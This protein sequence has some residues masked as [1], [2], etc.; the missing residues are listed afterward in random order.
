MEPSSARWA[1][2]RSVNRCRSRAAP[3]TILGP[4]KVL[5]RLQLLLAAAACSFAKSRCTGDHRRRLF[6]VC[7]TSGRFAR[8]LSLRWGG[9]ADGG[10]IRGRRSRRLAFEGRF[11]IRP[12]DGRRRRGAWMKG[13][14]RNS[15][16]SIAPTC[17]KSLNTYRAQKRLFLVRH[18]RRGPNCDA[19]N[20]ATDILTD[21]TLFH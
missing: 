5:R 4:R 2:R 17:D 7:A 6:A 11:A 1:R 10:G 18:P 13:S 19:R 9:A 16:G 15:P 21:T 3:T 20:D 8:R 14:C 12:P